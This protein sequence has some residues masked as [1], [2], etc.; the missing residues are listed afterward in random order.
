MLNKNYHQ[1]IPISTGYEP[2]D[3]SIAQR[4]VYYV[5]RYILDIRTLDIS[6]IRTPDNLD[7][8]TLDISDIYTLDTLNI[9][10]PD[11]SDIQTCTL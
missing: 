3:T 9:H 4:P 11:I 10:T 2:G 1:I 7:I 6:D 8:Y 5:S